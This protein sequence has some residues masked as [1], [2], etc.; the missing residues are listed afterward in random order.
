[1]EVQPRRCSFQIET[2]ASSNPGAGAEDAELVTFWISQH[3][4]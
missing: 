4:P 1:M 2:S 3:N